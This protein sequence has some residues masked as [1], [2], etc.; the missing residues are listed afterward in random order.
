M[1]NKKVKGAA[2][3][4]KLKN[5]VSK[6]QKFTDKR[7]EATR[8]KS[9]KKKKVKKIKKSKKVNKSKKIKKDKKVN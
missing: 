2:S 6:C 9:K 7:Q 5:I 3:T 8:I 1:K 4:D